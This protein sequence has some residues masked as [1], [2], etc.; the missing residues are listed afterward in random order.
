MTKRFVIVVILGLLLNFSTWASMISIF[1]V[2]TG[3]S[4]NR[5]ES[6][7][8]V[9]W[10]N[11]FLDVF[12]DSGYIVSNAPILRLDKKPESEN[13]LLGEVS[14][15]LQDARRA[16]IDYIL[17]TILDFSGELQFPGKISFYIYNLNTEE[18]IIERE[19]AGK[20]YRSTGEEFEDLKS[21]ARGFV[22]FF[23][24]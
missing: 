21:I 23:G 19:I 18:R 24:Q 14:L 16:G 6:P 13:G 15:D 3:L 4:N 22:P 5:T 8:S 1:V 11:A 17:I 9:Q 12:F 2:E 20:T 10:E 7:H